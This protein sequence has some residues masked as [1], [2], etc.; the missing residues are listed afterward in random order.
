MVIHTFQV[1]LYFELFE[2]FVYKN[3][4]QIN[5]DGPWRAPYV[6]VDIDWPH[7]V[8]NDKPLGKWLLYLEELP[9]VEGNGECTVSEK[10][11]NPLNL[12]AKEQAASLTSAAMTQ[13]TTLLRHSRINKSHSFSEYR[14]KASS[15]EKSSSGEKKPSNEE[16]VLNRVRRDRSMI[17]RAEKL[18]DKD[19]KKT[20]IVSM[21]SST[22]QTD[23]SRSSIIFSL[24]GL[25]AQNCQMH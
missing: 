21:V 7:Q 18:I 23:T 17:I 16:N 3:L 1:K 9:I 13:D 15:A 12:Q 22:T 4:Q 14:E 20:N 6:E 11:V 25:Q 5:N 24:L 2:N 10:L 8:G 19:G